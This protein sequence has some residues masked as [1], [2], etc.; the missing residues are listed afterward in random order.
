MARGIT[1]WIGLAGTCLGLAALALS[2]AGALHPVAD[3]LAVFRPAIALA[4]VPC[5]VLVRR[6]MALAVLGGGAAIAALGPVLWLALPAGAGPG[7]PDGG[8]TLYQKN[9]LWSNEAHAEL[10]ADIEASG[11]DVVTLQE[12]SA[13]GGALLERLSGSYPAQAIC[14]T[15]PAGAVAV[16]SRRAFVAP[17]VCIEGQVAVLA[18][19]RRGRSG[20]A[21]CTC[22]GPGHGPRRGRPSGWRARWRPWR[23]SGSS[24]GIS[25]WWP[26]ADRFGGWRRRRG[27]GR[28]GRCGAAS[29]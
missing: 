19:V 7:A 28:S 5:L 29:F 20:S 15:G 16:L 23:D 25:T 8:V 22:H 9:M 17:P 4:L 3:S 2:H 10:A 11:A 14:P 26:G 13:R 27:P 12:V 1:Y 21:R 24:P 6:D 18:R